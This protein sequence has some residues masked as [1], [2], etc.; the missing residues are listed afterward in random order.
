[1]KKPEINVVVIPLN[2]VDA[3]MPI[4]IACSYNL[5]NSISIDISKGESVKIGEVNMAPS[6]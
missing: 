3:Y 6:N 2:L 5:V 4:I 1:M